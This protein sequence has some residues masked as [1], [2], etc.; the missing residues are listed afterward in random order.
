MSPFAPA[1]V[2]LNAINCR[3]DARSISQISQAGRHHECFQ[4]WSRA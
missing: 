1:R 3:I 4:A 2:Q